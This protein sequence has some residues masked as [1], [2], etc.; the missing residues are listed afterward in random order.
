MSTP[1]GGRRGHRHV[2]LAAPD[3]RDGVDETAAVPGSDPGVRTAAVT[4]DQ[5]H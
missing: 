3:G 5:I 1:E 2:N 4:K